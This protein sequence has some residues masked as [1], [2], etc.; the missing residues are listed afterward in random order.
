MQPGIFAS[1]HD[2]ESSR[3]L[4]HALPLA[5]LLAACG[6]NLTP[7]MPVGPADAGPALDAGPGA[8]CIAEA[9]PLQNPRAFP[10]G[11]TFYLP[12]LISAPG[13]PGDAAWRIASAPAGSENAIYPAGAPAPRFTPDRAGEYVFEVPGVAESEQRL[14]VVAFTP[15]ERFRNHHLTPLFGAAQVGD[16]IW[17][18]NGASYTVTRVAQRDGRWIAIDTIPVGA[19]PAAVAWREPLPY[20][21][22][23]LRG[24]DT[25]GFLDRDRGVLTDA[26][27]V[28]DEPT[29]LAISPDAATLYVSLATM[30]EIAVVNLTTRTIT[31]RIAVGFD[32]RALALSADGTRL[33]VA[34]YRSGNPVKDTLGSYDED[35]GDIWIVDTAAH[36]VTETITGVSAD[37]RAL[38]LDPAGGELYVAATDGD[39][40][41]SQADPDALPFVHEVVAVAADPQRAD[42]GQVLR[43]A[44]LTR[45]PGA[46]GPAVNPGG[47]AVTGD[48]VWIAAESSDQVLMLDRATLAEIGRVEVGAGPR[49]ILA[50][51]D[52]NLAVHCFQSF[53]LWILDNAGQLVDI[54]TLAE[55]PRP[56]DVALGERV[57]YRPGGRFA[58]NHACTSCHTEAQN[59]GMVWHFGPERRSNIRPLQLLDATTPI[60]WDG[61]VSSSENFGYQG[62][63]SIVGRPAMPDEAAALGAFLGSLL[64]AP[65]ANGHTRLDGSYTE[66]AL[67]GQALFEGKAGCAACHTPPLYTGRRTIEVGKSGEPADIPSLLGVYRHGV[68]FVKAQARSLEAALDVAI[69]YAGAVLTPA[70]R[71]DLLAFLQQLTPKGSAPLAMWPDLGNAEAVPPGVQ[72]Y[73]TFADPVDD[74]RDDRS[75][76]EVAAAFVT[77]EDADGNAV[78]AT[79]AITGAPT[80]T[81]AGALTGALTGGSHGHRI[82]LTPDAP[83][84]PGATYRFRVRPGVPFLSGGVL[85]AE[86]SSTFT[87]TATASATLPDV[88]QMVAT[89]YGPT[90]A[91]ELPLQLRRGEDQA[92]ERIFVI[93]PQLFGAQQRQA[94][95]V[96]LDGERFLMEPFALP[97]SPTG[98]AGDAR[99]IIGAITATDAEGR[100]TR[101]EGTFALRAPGRSTPG[102]PFV[103]TAPAPP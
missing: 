81:I 70:E 58:S 19:W 11:E 51:A 9:L 16:E 64:G 42:H 57:F 7:G 22:V 97:V 55:D 99:D 98:A 2:R 17:V 63:G 85:E 8:A 79:I 48:M 30:R 24:S 87:V 86:R 33:F 28:G 38:A 34:S 91:V 95:W 92:G 67:R 32:P 29:G 80:G 82:V 73:V 3:L 89:V 21:V 20:G 12:A 1:E 101:I 78:P 31:T 10:L 66:A 93:E 76:A 61:Y 23:A 83:L 39:P 47:V 46:A 35:E 13:C 103:I 56:A 72:P 60:G 36:T 59:D 102:L 4:R 68:Y 43:R 88:M 54:V 25:I 45:Q 96:R 65:R 15:A 90:G 77:L 94:V 27:W 37:L 84:R 41:P 5:A 49:Q 71:D 69:P 18:A 100:A 44:D 52:G 26:L 50:L 6:D 14:T 62:P 53:E 74:T 75:A 40:I